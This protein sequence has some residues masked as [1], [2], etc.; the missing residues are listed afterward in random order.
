VLLAL[1]IISTVAAVSAALSALGLLPQWRRAAD[2]QT[3]VIVVT[4]IEASATVRQPYRLTEDDQ[5]PANLAA[6]DHP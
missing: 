1:A 3:V 6:E 2:P 5:G 4:S